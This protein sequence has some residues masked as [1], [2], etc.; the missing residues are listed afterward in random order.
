MLL[1]SLE[2][3]KSVTFC[4]GNGTMWGLDEIYMLYRNLSGCQA[5]ASW[6]LCQCFQQIVSARASLSW[7][8][9]YGGLDSVLLWGAVLGTGGCLQHLWPRPRDISSIPPPAYLCH[10]KMCPDIDRCL[11]VW[12]A[13][14]VA[15]ENQQSRERLNLVW[16]IFGWIL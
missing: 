3:L 11:L 7:H 15:V 6:Q 9:R 14:S 1:A 5:L 2:M 10:L 12:G 16:Y 13:K 4:S 8:Y